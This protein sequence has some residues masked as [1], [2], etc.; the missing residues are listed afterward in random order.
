MQYDHR[1]HDRL[2]LISFLFTRSSLCDTS[3]RESS[4]YRYFI[5][6]MS[7]VS[8]SYYIKFI[9]TLQHE[10]VVPAPPKAEEAST[11]IKDYGIIEAKRTPGTQTH[12]RAPQFLNSTLKNTQLQ[13]SQSRVRVLPQRCRW[14]ALGLSQRSSLLVIL[15][16]PLS[17]ILRWHRHVHLWGVDLDRSVVRDRRDSLVAV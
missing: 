8:V 4:G 16:R 2:I 15:R 17:R 10:K 5:L 11:C 7:G 14:R 13:S 12:I 1:N 6:R 9:K 3:T